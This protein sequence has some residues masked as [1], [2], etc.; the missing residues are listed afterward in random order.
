MNN[1]GKLRFA[2]FVEVCNY[3]CYNYD[4]GV[5]TMKDN[6]QTTDNLETRQSIYNYSRSALTF[7][8]WVASMI[9]V[10]DRVSVLELGCGNGL[11]WESLVS[12]ITNSRIILSDVSE[13]MIMEAR[14]RLHLHDF[15]FENIDF[16]DIPYPKSSF[17]LV[18][19]NHN[20]Y[21]SE[22]L[23]Q[24][25]EQVHRVMKPN[26]MFVCTANSKDHLYQLNDLLVKFEIIDQSS[27]E[28]MNRF[29]FENSKQ[30]LSRKFE[31]IYSDQ[32]ENILHVT[33]PQVV[34]DYFYSYLDNKNAKEVKIREVE[35]IKYI[36]NEIAEKGYY[37]VT[38]LPFICISIKE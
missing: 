37:E 18:I 32:F 21:H 10:L 31:V 22:D 15:K 23:D 14:R 34:L 2:F 28:L 8:N 16:N 11:L 17:D 4:K 19:S 6:Y 27:K 7:N 25:L 29:S 12:K 38:A 9:P 33:N 30:K 3:D 5:M 26:G 20:L 36:S 13:K 35:I 1:K 24:T